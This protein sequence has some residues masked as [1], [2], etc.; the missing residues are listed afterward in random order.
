MGTGGAFVAKGDEKMQSPCR[1][2]ARPRRKLARPLECPG[3]CIGGVF[4]AG[5]SFQKGVLLQPSLPE[6]VGRAALAGCQGRQK[7]HGG[8]T[9]PP[10]PSKILGCFAEGD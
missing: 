2:T 7:V 5:S 8:G 4:A 9:L 3:P 6:Q 10:S 1:A